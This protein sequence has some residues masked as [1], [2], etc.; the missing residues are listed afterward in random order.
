M[1]RN[2]II[3]VGFMG[4]GKSSVGRILSDQ[5]NYEFKDT[6]EMIESIEDT[7]IKKIFSQ[8]GEEFFRDLET[9]LLLSIKDTL[10]KT[11]LSTGGGM[12]IYERNRK[13]LKSMGQVVFLRATR[14]TIIDRLTGDNTRP[15]LKGNKLEEKV[16]KLLCD[17][18]FY[19]EEVADVII[20]T[21][22]KSIEDIVKEI[23]ETIG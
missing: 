10:K 7:T 21:D 16:D 19:Y 15:L 11:V 1:A 20:D 13:L 22:N 18:M 8:H 9:T 23:I 4:S 2:N 5:L 14:D 17:R 6:D 3:L 12:P